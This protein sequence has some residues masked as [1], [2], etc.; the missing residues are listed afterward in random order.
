MSYLESLAV[1]YT[2][3]ITNKIDGKRYYGCRYSAEASH[4]D[5]GKNYFSSSRRVQD[6]IMRIGI[7]NFIFEI[8]HSFR[9]EYIEVIE[10]RL[11]RDQLKDIVLAYESKVLRRLNVAKND[12]WYNKFV[13]YDVQKK[14]IDLI[15]PVLSIEESQRCEAQK[16]KALDEN[17]ACRE[18]LK[19]RKYNLRNHCEKTS[20][21]QINIFSDIIF[22][23]F[24]SENQVFRCSSIQPRLRHI[25][26]KPVMHFSIWTRDIQLCQATFSDKAKLLFD[27]MV[28]PHI[29]WA[30]ISEYEFYEPC[31][32]LDQLVFRIKLKI[33]SLEKIDANISIRNFYFSIKNLDFIGYRK[34]FISFKVNPYFMSV[35]E[36]KSDGDFEIVFFLIKT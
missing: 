30:D 4:N 12:A 24:E 6:E 13:N 7:D 18:K 2:Y 22:S 28:M 14:S 32:A 16:I 17:K 1:P 8:R 9:K 10:G 33:F 21:D 3:L 29:K 19:K 36:R 11:S 35:N 34:T 27:R 5:L 23:N 15:S 20:E 26:K 25:I 31:E